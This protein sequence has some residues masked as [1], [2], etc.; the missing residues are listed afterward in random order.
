MATGFSPDFPA[1]A[2]EYEIIATTAKAPIEKTR[3]VR[4]TSTRLDGRFTDF[5]QR[6]LTRSARSHVAS[7]WRL[8]EDKFTN[9]RRDG[10]QSHEESFAC[11]RRHELNVDLLVGG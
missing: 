3:S 1:A 6:G 10:R 2:E 11:A 5:L 8:T 4:N 7:Y 9:E